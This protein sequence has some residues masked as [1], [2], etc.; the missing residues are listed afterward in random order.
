ML[1]QK[2]PETAPVQ[3][4]LF[5]TTELER[6]VHDRQR[7]EDTTLRQ[8]LKRLPERDNLITTSSVPVNRL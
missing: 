3:G 7:W 6:L 1:E 5:D 8:S 4:T 2:I